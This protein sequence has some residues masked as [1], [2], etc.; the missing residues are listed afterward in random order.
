[1]V[2]SAAASRGGVVKH[3]KIEKPRPLRT[4]PDKVRLREILRLVEETR[5]G[6]STARN[7]TNTRK[8]VQQLKESLR[9][10]GAAMEKD[11]KDCLDLLEADLREAV[12]DP[13]LDLVIRICLLEIIEL[14]LS[15]WIST[16]VMVNMYRQKLAEAQLDIDMRKIGYHEDYVE[17]DCN[18]NSISMGWRQKGGSG[19]DGDCDEP[20]YKE[21]LVVDGH[22]VWI[23]TTSEKIAS[24]SKE[25]LTEFFAIMKTKSEAEGVEPL[26]L[27]KPEIIYDKEELLRLSKSPLCKDTPYNWEKIST[28]IPFIVKKAGASGKHFLREVESIKK[29]EAARKM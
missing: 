11:H 25:V 24:T 6:L 16:P 23:T 27:I 13:Q 22:E 28:D 8:T 26:C 14:R 9:L 21:S 17:A 2:D 20:R 5:K 19:P 12:D 1:M 10:N 4:D 15:N 7:E 3:L 18:H 29:Q